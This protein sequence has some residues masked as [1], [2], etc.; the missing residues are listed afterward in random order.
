M[1]VAELRSTGCQVVP[2]KFTAVT[3]KGPM[4]MENIIARFPGKS[5]KAVV[6]TGHYDTKLLPGNFVGANDGGSSTGFLL[7]LARAAAKKP[8][9]HD[10]YLV[11]F[12]GEEAIGPWSEKDGLHGSRHL[13]ERWQ[14]EG[15]LA[16]I[17]ALIN[18]DM[19]GDRNLKLLAEHNSNPALRRLIWQT[20]EDL[21]YGAYLDRV[22][23]YIEDDHMPFVRRGVAAVDLIDFEY[24]PSNT[25]WHTAED[26]VDK[27]SADSFQVLGNLILEVIRRLESG[28]AL[29]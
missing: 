20:A 28:A 27:L 18:V 25:Y 6:I 13:A 9:A 1:I 2:D 10:L 24:G 7:E 19:I 15:M 16:K 12:D 8:R 23:S 17:L 14:R 22:P 21:G 5:G 11:W 4:A 3:P 29:R 26:T